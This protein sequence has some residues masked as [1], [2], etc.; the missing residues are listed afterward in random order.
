MAT[1]WKFNKANKL[2][3][4]RQLLGQLAQEFGLQQSLGS[5]FHQVTLGRSCHSGYL[6]D[7]VWLWLSEPGMQKVT[8]WQLNYE[9]VFSNSSRITAKRLIA[10]SV[11]ILED[12]GLIIYPVRLGYALGWLMAIQGAS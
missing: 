4:E 1:A 10:Q 11:R 3:H 9:S 5:D 6:E 8:Q 12:Q 7:Q 2:P